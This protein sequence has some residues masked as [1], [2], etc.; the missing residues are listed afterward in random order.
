MPVR[1]RI[2]ADRTPDSEQPLVLLQ[3]WMKWWYETDEAPNKMP[4]A[5]HVRTAV[6]L[7]TAGM[8]VPGHD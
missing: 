1:V 7:A 6:A 3:E 4:N 5:L 8:E 2:D